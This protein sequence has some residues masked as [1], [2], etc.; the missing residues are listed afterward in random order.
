MV[1]ITGRKERRHVRIHKKKSKR[2]TRT[3]YPTRIG[4]KS[5]TGNNTEKS[6]QI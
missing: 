6:K 4:R 5:G 3:E 1:A 2:N